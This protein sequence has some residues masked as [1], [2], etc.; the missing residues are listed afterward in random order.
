[1]C[2]KFRFLLTKRIES[3]IEKAKQ[4]EKWRSE[5]M[6]EWILFD[7]ARTEGF[8]AGLEQGMR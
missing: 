4:N 7:D 6:K 1:M 5:Y 2:T 8:Q 3:A